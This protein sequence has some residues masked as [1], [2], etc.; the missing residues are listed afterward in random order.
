MYYFLSSTDGKKSYSLRADVT[1]EIQNLHE[2]VMHQI[3]PYFSDAEA[4]ED[5]IFG[6]IDKMGKTFT[7]F[8]EKYSFSN[9]DPHITLL[10]HQVPDVSLPIEFTAGKI[11]IYQ[12]GKSCT[13]RNLLYQTNLKK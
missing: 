10:A 12:L 6:D 11:A 7:N 2:T 1:K 4:T 5:M 13:C 9:F 8:S 3:A